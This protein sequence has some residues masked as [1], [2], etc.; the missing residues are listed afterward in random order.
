M[1]KL[2]EYRDSYSDYAK[3]AGVLARQLAY[4]GFAV[5]W[6]F[7]AGGQGPPTVP[8]GLF[9]PGALFVLALGADLLQS[10]TGSVTWSVY[11]N[12]NFNRFKDEEKEMSPSPKIKWPIYAFYYVKL[13][14]VLVGYAF[15]LGYL[16]NNL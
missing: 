4:A 6:V 9:W 14:S 11:Y 15:L 10:I 8:H 16:K 2:K 5:I 3:Q 12:W 13:A 7:K 1:G